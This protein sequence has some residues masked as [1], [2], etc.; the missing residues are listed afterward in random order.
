MTAIPIPLSFG[1]LGECPSFAIALRTCISHCFGY[2]PVKTLF[3][4]VSKRKYEGGIILIIRG[5]PGAPA[6]LRSPFEMR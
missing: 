4:S 1:F 3:I 5:A 6:L 2:A